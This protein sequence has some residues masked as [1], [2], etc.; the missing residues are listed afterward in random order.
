MSLYE[1]MKKRR[2]TYI[3]K[4]ISNIINADK[5]ANFMI[6]ADKNTDSMFNTENF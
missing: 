2:M 3:E 1:L 4:I 6:N 5:Y